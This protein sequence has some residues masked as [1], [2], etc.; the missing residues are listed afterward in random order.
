SVFGTKQAEKNFVVFAA[1]PLEAASLLRK[2]LYGMLQ[3]I[4]NLTA[5]TAA[6]SYEL[7]AASKSQTQTTKDPPRRACSPPRRACSPPRRACSTREICLHFGKC[8]KNIVS[9]R[10]A[11]TFSLNCFGISRKS[12]AAEVAARVSVAPP[13]I[14]VTGNGQQAI[15]TEDCHPLL[16]CYEK[17]SH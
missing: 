1:I 3:R 17:T 9:R 4:K 8:W 14:Q 2:S 13:K 11:A 15:G 10:Y 12:V 16:R 6:T 5:R 7:R